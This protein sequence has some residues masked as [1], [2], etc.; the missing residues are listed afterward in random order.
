LLT[1]LYPI[2]ELTK[3]ALTLAIDLAHPVYDCFYLSLAQRE[4]AVLI[5]A[6]E[7]MFAVAR[8]ARIK[9]NRL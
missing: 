6:D 3:Q 2:G 9:V 8:K 1:R 5:T 4:N 7:C